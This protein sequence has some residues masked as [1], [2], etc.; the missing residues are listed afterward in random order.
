MRDEWRKPIRALHS[1]PRYAGRRQKL[2][3]ID[4]L[5]FVCKKEQGLQT[6]KFSRL[7]VTKPKSVSLSQPSAGSNEWDYI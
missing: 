6:V 3:R 4:I 5:V 1:R 2:E 7:V